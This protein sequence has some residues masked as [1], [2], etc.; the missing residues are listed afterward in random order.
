MRWMLAP[1]IVLVVIGGCRSNG[2]TPI[3]NATGRVADGIEHAVSGAND[4]GPANLE[5]R[6]NPANCGCPPHE[7]FAYGRWMRVFVE[8][9]SAA[10]AEL[11]K[12]G[13]LAT[14]KVNGR[15]EG[16][17]RAA[18]NGVSYRVLAVL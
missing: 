7:V 14:V 10:I 1:L 16:K 6:Y 5:V 12:A 9:T 13:P 17:P 15:F 3:Q 18:D 2:L 4:S 11:R 8:P